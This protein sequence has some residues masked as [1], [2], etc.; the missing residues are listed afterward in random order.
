[1][2]SNVTGRALPRAP[3]KPGSIEQCGVPSKFIER[4]SGK[5]YVHEKT[6]KRLS[7]YY[8]KGQDLWYNPAHI[9]DDMQRFVDVGVDSVCIAIHESNLHHS[10][11]EYICEEAVKRKLAILGVPSRI[12]GLVAGWHRGASTVSA[13]HPELWARNEDGTPVDCFGPMLSVHHPQSAHVVAEV[14]KRM[15][16]KFPLS[17]IIWDEV[18]SLNIADHSDAARNALGRPAQP[19]DQPPATAALFSQV[20]RALSAHQP[21]LRISMFL[22]SDMPDELMALM[23]T[24]EGLDEFGCDGACLREEDP[25]HGVGGSGKKLLPN[26]ERFKKVSRANGLHSFVLIETQ[27]LEPAALQ[28]SIERLP[29]LCAL[30]VDHLVYYDYP[31]GMDDPETLMPRITAAMRRWRHG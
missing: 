10:N 13:L 5:R 25:F 17:G 9:R 29:E 11:V 21:N 28:R 30:D 26:I 16:D 15:L 31:W 14:A 19:A 12:G 27:L 3:D 20:N 1:M 8:F 2:P 18:K 23:G 6:M 24:V 7:T 22:Y 4:H